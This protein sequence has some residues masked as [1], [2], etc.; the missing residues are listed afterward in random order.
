MQQ[1]SFAA[2]GVVVFMCARFNMTVNQTCLQETLSMC[3]S[4][5]NDLHK[6]AKQH[7]MLFSPNFS[8]LLCSHCMQCSLQQPWQMNAQCLAHTE[9]AFEE[10][11]PPAHAP[12]QTCPGSTAMTWQTWTY[13]I[14]IMTATC[15]P[16]S[17]TAAA[18][19]ALCQNR[20]HEN[21]R[22]PPQYLPMPH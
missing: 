3:A 7:R 21:R 8:P 22:G 18:A 1:T 2:A 9:H 20:E 12:C 19:S 14:P 10:I 15:S 4:L 17:S 6:P 13:M 11:H 16:H 5:Q